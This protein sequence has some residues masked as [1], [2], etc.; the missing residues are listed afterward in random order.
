MTDTPLSDDYSFSRFARQPFYQEENARLVALADLRPGQ[1]VVDLACGPG[2]VTRLILERIRGARESLVIGVD[3]SAQALHQAR[4][5]YANVRDAIVQFVE[6]RAEELSRVVRQTM[7]A[8]ILCNA[9]HL[10]SNKAEVIQEISRTLRPG[11]VFAFNTAFY[12]G[13]QPPETEAF[14]RRWMLR[15]IRIL[16]SEH[17][18]ALDRSIKVMARQQLT[19]A[20]YRDLLT[21][22]G[23]RVVQE[24]VQ[25]VQVPLEGWLD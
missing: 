3:L 19:P 21:S 5:D 10:M 15:A 22:A 16:R 23:L 14:Y 18:M 6:A 2:S 20:E 8:V 12:L 13:S 24:R 17:Q 25:I 11:G 9:I 1:R 4:Q 7:D